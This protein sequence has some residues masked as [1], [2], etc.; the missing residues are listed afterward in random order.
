MIP[1]ELIERLEP[2]CAAQREFVNPPHDMCGTSLR[3]YNN[4]K[5][6][7]IKAITANIDN[8][9]LTSQEKMQE[10]AQTLMYMSDKALEGMA[11]SGVE[12]ALSC[13]VYYNDE[14]RNEDYSE[15]QQSPNDDY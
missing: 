10:F 11:R 12:E 14:L 1:R 5:T 7:A 2:I 4:D 6:C 3:R 8:A 9:T 15:Y 13:D